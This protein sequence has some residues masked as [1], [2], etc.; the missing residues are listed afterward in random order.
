MGGMKV[1][2]KR[3]EG[4]DRVSHVD[5]KCRVFNGRGSFPSIKR[6]CGI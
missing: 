5:G 4:N 1:V 6:I 2:N 3:K